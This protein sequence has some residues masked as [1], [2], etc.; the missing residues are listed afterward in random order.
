MNNDNVTNDN[1]T[2][3]LFASRDEVLAKELSIGLGDTIN[4]KY[5]QSV[6]KRYSE[7]LL[8]EIFER[9]RAIPQSQI[10]KSKGAL[11]NYLLQKHGKDYHC[12]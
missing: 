8:R 10:K 5:Y 7:R 12:N 6:T 9:V 2:Q 1:D 11:F 4:L 3:P